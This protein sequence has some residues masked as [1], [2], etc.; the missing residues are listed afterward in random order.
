[1]HEYLKHWRI[2][3]L[4]TLYKTLRQ[5]GKIVV[6]DYD[7]QWVQKENISETNF[8]EHI[9]TDGNEKRQM[10]KEHNCKQRH[11]SYG[12]EDCIRDCSKVGFSEVLKERCHIRTPWGIKSKIFLY[13]G[14]KA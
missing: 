12:L 1:M 9:F 11:T 14:K 2:P 3:E 13:V 8:K 6:V 7:L 10:R 4:K 5:N